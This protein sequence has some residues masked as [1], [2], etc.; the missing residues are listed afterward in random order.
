MPRPRWAIHL[1]AA[2]WRNAM[3]AGM[4]LH[5]CAAPIP[6]DLSFTL[7]IPSTLS[8]VPGKIGL[9][10][11]TPPSYIQPALRPLHPVVVNFHGGGFTLGHSTDDARWCAA[12]TS[13]LNAVVISVDYRLAPEH[14]FPTAVEDGTDVLLW[15]EAHAALYSLDASRVAISGFSAGGNMCFS[16]PLRLSYERSLHCSPTQVLAGPRLR[17][18]AIA[19]FYPS[20]DFTAPRAQRRATNVRPE[21]ELPKLF[22]DLFDASYLYP[23]KEVPLDSPFLSPAVATDNDVKAALP[24]DV[25]LVICEWDELRAEGERWGERLKDLG[26]RVWKEVVMGVAH[27]WDKG[28]NPVFEDAKARRVYGSVCEQLG[29]AFYGEDWKNEVFEGSDVGLAI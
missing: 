14:P 18:A 3:A 15:L 26:V 21:M 29:R 19:A 13:Q 17:L 28:P 1:E 23:P 2:F 20:T 7:E 4:Y 10:F 16:V 22:T 6:P 8:K 25:M 12:V 24:S 11:Y 5:K 9:S 27:G